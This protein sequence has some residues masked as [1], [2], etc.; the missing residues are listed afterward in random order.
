MSF[1]MDIR[2]L[3]AKSGNFCIVKT[4]QFH[5]GSPRFLVRLMTL[6]WFLQI[7]G[8]ALI[9]KPSVMVEETTRID[10][11]L[12]A[13]MVSNQALQNGDFKKTLE[14]YEI[15]KHSTDD[16][17]ARKARYGIACTHLS[18]AESPKDVREAIMLWN[19]WSEQAPPYLED[20]DPRILWLLLKQKILP[21]PKKIRVTKE[22]ESEEKR[23][24]ENLLRAKEE[25]VQRLNKRL[26]A[27]ENE[28][29]TILKKQ[30]D[31]VGIM[32]SEIQTL[33]DKINSFE[34][35]DQKIKE[36]KKEVSSP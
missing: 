19:A 34:A 1:L 33:R 26:K 2:V 4:N 12:M 8:C 7:L 3:Q 17:I 5:K 15:L 29:Q 27:M 35:I 30:A 18:L 31:Y 28:I 22:A 21:K 23:Q 9:P 16:R 13:L 20:E 36:K 32:E 14:G 24:L 10:P 6:V 25:E 11:D